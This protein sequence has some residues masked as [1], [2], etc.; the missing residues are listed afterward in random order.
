[1]KQSPDIFI[2]S[3]Y[4][5]HFRLMHYNVLYVIKLMKFIRYDNK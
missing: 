5:N 4:H 2:Y 1:M 3:L